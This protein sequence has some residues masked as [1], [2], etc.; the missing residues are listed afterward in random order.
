MLTAQLC[1]NTFRNKE[2]S[3]DE[4]IFYSKRLIRLLIEYAL[5]LLPFRVSHQL[6]FI[7]LCLYYV[8][9][10]QLVTGW[11]LPLSFLNANYHWCCVNR[12]LN[13]F[14][15]QSVTVETPQG[16]AYEGKRMDTGKVSVLSLS[17]SASLNTCRVLILECFAQLS[18]EVL[19]CLFLNEW[20]IRILLT[21]LTV[22][23]L[24]K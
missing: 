9:M 17:L 14:S 20:F 22:C 8:M 11:N 13:D 3:R 15:L 4:F 5:S 1:V 24:C 23:L 2:T 6:I 10:I 12:K 7:H 19:F 18:I 16:V 21:D